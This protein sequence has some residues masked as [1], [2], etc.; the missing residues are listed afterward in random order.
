MIIIK[1]IV[2]KSDHYLVYYQDKGNKQFKY[3][4][5]RYGPFALLL[6]EKSLE[7]G[8]KYND[9]F[10]TFND[11]TIFYVYT[12][13]YG[14]KLVYVDN[15]DASLFYDKKISISKDNH[16]KTYYAKING[17]SVHRLIMNPD[18]SKILV[19]HINQNG[20][21]NRKANL[22][23]VSTQLNNKNATVRIDSPLGIKGVTREL[24]YGHYRYYMCIR[25]NSG[26]KINRSFSS[27]VYGEEEAFLMAVNTRLELELQYG[28]VQQE[29][30][31]TIEKVLNEI[32]SRT[33]DREPSGPEVEGA[34]S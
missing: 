32:R 25:D 19:D 2:E 8:I 17:G 24:V 11:Y 5:E 14:T 16:A 23:L 34:T 33:G 9:Y 31:E 29:C 27:S 20:L 21:D 15:E 13:A 3:N 1:R 10:R 12:K 26:K 7:T 4:K 18:N 28:Y 30:S 22:R 6:A